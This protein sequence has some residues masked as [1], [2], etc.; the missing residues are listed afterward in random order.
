MYVGV[1]AL[2]PYQLVKYHWV[3]S[4]CLQI[5]IV[6]ADYTSMRFFIHLNEKDAKPH[7]KSALFFVGMT[8]HLA[9]PIG[10][11]ITT[12]EVRRV[13]SSLRETTRHF[14]R[15]YLLYHIKTDYIHKPMCYM[16]DKITYTAF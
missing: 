3:Y 8:C 2:K 15:L 5:N 13:C 4:Q 7:F 10:W 14:F 6:T 1:L 9:M 12:R 16:T 11:A